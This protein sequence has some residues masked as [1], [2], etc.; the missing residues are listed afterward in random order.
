M[1]GKSVF[2]KVDH[3]KE[4]LDIMDFVKLKIQEAER[5]IEKLRSLRAKED[6]E[7]DAWA[8]KLDD[9]KRKI[10]GLYSQVFAPE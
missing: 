10:T 8:E 5:E 7:I 3:Y 6:E 9:I 2:V 1:D 4:L